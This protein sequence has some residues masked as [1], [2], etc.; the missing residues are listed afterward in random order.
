[1][2]RWEGFARSA[3]FAALAAVGLVPWLVLAG[4]LLGPPVALRTYLVGLL[5]VYVAGLGGHRGRRI[6]AALGVAAAGLGVAAMTHSIAEC[7]LGLAALLGVVRGTILYRARPA[8]ELS[9][10]T[11]GLLFARFLAGRSL[12][13]MMLAV[14]GFFLVQSVFFLLGGVSERTAPTRHPDPFEEA[15]R[16][17][18]ALLGGGSV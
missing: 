8:T 3:C 10:V 16:R 12:V 11:A 7:A 1:M 9:L 2:M 14:W 15:H 18:I 4:P 13:S 6:A 17:A 5:S